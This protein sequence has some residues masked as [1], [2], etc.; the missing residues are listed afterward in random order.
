[1]PNVRVKGILTGGPYPELTEPCAIVSSSGFVAD[2]DFSG[3]KLL[4]LS[5]ERNHVHAIIRRT[6]DKKAKDPIFEAEGNWSESLTFK[7]SSGKTIDTIDVS[8]APSTEF[9]A[10]PLEKQDSWESR[11]A[12]NGVISSIQEGNMQG[13]ADSKNKL[14]NAQRE[15]RKKPETSEE[16][17]KA[18][19]FT[20][21]ND[22]PVA[23][24]LLD[25]VGEKLDVQS[26]QGIWR[27][28]KEKWSQSQRPWR[29]EL[30]P[31]G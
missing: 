7:D 18:L 29:G 27:F 16:N 3:K 17:W 22:D 15:L 14:E 2:V 21:E 25:V 5:G 19:F 9:R 4:G 23:Q 10:L 13:V 31:Y 8:S 6:D 28:D 20:K 1:L 12:W 26:T 11:K 24:K 30:T